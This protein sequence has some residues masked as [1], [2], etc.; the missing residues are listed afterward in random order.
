MISRT[1]LFGPAVAA[2]LLLFGCAGPRKTVTVPVEPGPHAIA[3]RA[4]NF[5]FQPGRIE[6]R[7]GSVL[8][9]SVENVSGMTH[10]LTVKDP[11]GRMVQSVPLPAKKT[12]E[13]EVK[14][15]Q[16]GEYPFYC[17]IPMHPLMGMRGIIDVRP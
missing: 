10:N 5:D 6:A 4:S 8:R 15:D 12:T 11:A 14:V 13:V 7:P 9:F 16:A 3:L 2:M 17:D 1:R